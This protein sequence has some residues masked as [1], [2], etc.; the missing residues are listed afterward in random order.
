LLD[1]FKSYDRDVAWVTPEVDGDV[2]RVSF[3]A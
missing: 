1:A 3:R 2:V